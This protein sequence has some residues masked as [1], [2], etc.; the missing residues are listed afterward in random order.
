MTAGAAANA[1]VLADSSTI[2][3]ISFFIGFSIVL[4]ES[5]FVHKKRGGGGS[6]PTSIP[7]RAAWPVSNNAIGGSACD[8]M[9]GSDGITAV[10]AEQN[11]VSPVPIARWP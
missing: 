1:A 11:A 7:E 9:R 8:E 2:A 10:Q 4:S 5:E 6:S 3:A